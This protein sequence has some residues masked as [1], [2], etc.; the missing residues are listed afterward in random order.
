MAWEQPSLF[1]DQE[2]GITKTDL[3]IIGLS[4][5]ARSGKDT[6]AKI[7]V[8]EYGYTRI[9]FADAI[10]EFLMGINP[11]LSDGYR[12]GEIVKLHGWEIA[13]AQ[14][15]VRRL[16]QETGTVARSLFGESFWVEILLSK[17]GP[18]DKIV[19]PD[20]RFSNE[21]NIVQMLGGAVWKVS[22]PGVGPINAHISES[23]MESYEVDA[24]IDNSGTI[25]DLTFVVRNLLV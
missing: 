9:G 23:D 10:R 3:G 13:K 20:V 24:E 25:E 5:Y 22:R 11:I 7:L 6:I 17:I 1:T 15:E 14:D 16:L 2:L 19:I 12:L 4:G 18:E 21:A 8:D